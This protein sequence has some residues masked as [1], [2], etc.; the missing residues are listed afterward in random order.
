MRRILVTLLAVV[1][2]LNAAAMAEPHV[3]IITIDGFAAYMMKDKTAP[4]PTLRKL[5]EEGAVAEGMKVANPSVTWPNH[6]TLISGVRPDKH[7]VLFNGI[8]M[9]PGAEMP[10]SIDPKRDASELVAVTTLPEILHKAGMRCA[11]IDWPC[12]RN[13]PAYEDNFSDV[14]EQVRWMTPKLREELVA[15]GELPDATDKSWGLLSAARKDQIWAA[16]ACHVIKARKPNLL[17]LHLLLTDGLQHKYGP[18][19]PG[20]YAAVGMA[21]A[22]L[23]DLLKALDDTG[24][25]EETTIFIVADHGFASASKLILPNVLF[26]KEGLLKSALLKVGSARVQA[27]SEGGTALVYFTNPQTM[28]EDKEKVRKLLKDAEGIEEIIEPDRYGE[29][30]YPLPE[31]NPQ[32]AELV[33]AAKADYA[34]SNKATG[35]DYVIPA[36]INTDNVGHHGYLNTNAKMN[37]VFIAVG[38]GIAKGTKVGVVE[39]VDVAPTAGYLL[40]VEIPGAEGKVMKEILSE[41]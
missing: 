11:S 28:S 29:F 21:D 36:T 6:T 23:R 8:L 20:A 15:M 3:V 16:A 41:K 31:K 12:T 19:T 22:H 10:V 40:G 39:N 17:L 27:L 2:C 38:R 7:G 18:Q 35:D 4:I 5:A 9:R 1:L 30:H 34:F 24:I 13:S 26:R 14:P 32:M 33:L 25:R 37:A